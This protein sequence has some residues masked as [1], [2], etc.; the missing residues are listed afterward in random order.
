[1]NDEFDKLVDVLN[2]KPSEQCV[3]TSI[4]LEDLF[5]DPEL[6]AKVAERPLSSAFE[7]TNVPA[8]NMTLRDKVFVFGPKEPV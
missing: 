1:M 8:R 7:Y 6:L 3:V 2:S 5:I 4:F